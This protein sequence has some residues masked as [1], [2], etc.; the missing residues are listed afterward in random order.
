MQAIKLLNNF[1]VDFHIHSTASDGRWTP[2]QLVQQV[3]QSGIGLF[4]V[5]D[6]DTIGSVAQAE[7]LACDGG[8][9]FLRGVEISSKVDGRLMHILAYGFDLT[10]ESLRQFLVANK[11]RLENYDDALLQILIDAGYE[12]DLAEYDAYSWERRRGGWKSLNFLIDKGFCGDVHG[13]FDKLFSGDLRVTFPNFPSPAEVVQVIQQAGGIPVWAHPANSLSKNGEHAPEDD[14]AVVAMMVAAGI[15]G[16]ECYTCHHDPEW[17]GRCL[18]WAA[19]YRLLVT[20]GSDSHGGFA[21]RR[22]GRPEVYWDDLLLGPIA[23]RV[24]R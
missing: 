6:H 8:L 21:G 10:N 9:A 22:L 5:T 11:A 24:I 2:E 1:R 3:R 19:R 7:A 18:A 15:E 12:I 4:A 13:F 17:T 23:E 16:L 14:E 20:G